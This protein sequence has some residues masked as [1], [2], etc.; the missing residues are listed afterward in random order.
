M[1][2]AATAT[3]EEMRKILRGRRRVQTA[4]GRHTTE[5]M[6]AA[7]RNRLDSRGERGIVNLLKNLVLEPRNPFEPTRPRAPRREVAAVGALVA[8]LIAAMFWFNFHPLR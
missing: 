8:V 6:L 7:F 3:T 2:A 4:P 5:E 1:E